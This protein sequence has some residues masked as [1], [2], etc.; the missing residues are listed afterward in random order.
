MTQRHIIAAQS[1]WRVELLSITRWGWLCGAGY[2]LPGK[3]KKQQTRQ[4]DKLG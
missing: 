1:H 3:L 4:V 2:I